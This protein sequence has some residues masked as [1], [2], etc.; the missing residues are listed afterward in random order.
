MSRSSVDE[1]KI[2]NKAWLKN[3]ALIV[4][5]EI[6]H[7]SGT[8]QLSK[9]LDCEFPVSIIRN[10]WVTLHFIRDYRPY[11]IGW[12]I[13]SQPKRLLQVIMDQQ[14]IILKLLFILYKRTLKLLRP[15]PR[16]L[17]FCKRSWRGCSV[18]ALFGRNITITDEES[19]AN[20]V[21]VKPVSM[22]SSSNWRKMHLGQDSTWCRVLVGSHNPLLE[23]PNVPPEIYQTAYCELYPR[24]KMIHNSLKNSWCAGD[25][26]RQPFVTVET[27][28]C[29]NGQV[30]L[31]MYI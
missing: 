30:I 28:V 1:L 18:V 4:L 10:I 22:N 12:C 15:L 9:A 21:F 7:Q 19:L 31:R 3:R 20:V 13:A 8:K 2:Q 16:C 29:V 14:G 6:N 17:T 25:T 11:P 27:F 5:R 24:R 23:F 26:K